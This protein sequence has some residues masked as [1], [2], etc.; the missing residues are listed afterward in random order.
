MWALKIKMH[1]IYILIQYSRQRYAPIHNSIASFSM[2]CWDRKHIF[3]SANTEWFSYW[4]KYILHINVSTIYKPW[5]QISF[6][7]PIYIYILYIYIY[8]IQT[9]IQWHWGPKQITKNTSIKNHDLYFLNS[10]ITW[11]ITR[12][13]HKSTKIWITHALWTAIITTF[14]EKNSKLGAAHFPNTGKIDASTLIRLTCMAYSI[15]NSLRPSDAYMC[16]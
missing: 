16:Q 6:W 2:Y 5:M 3:L 4:L 9:N 12:Y 10:F 13:S 11:P 15:L 1:A 14:I 7:W 8:D